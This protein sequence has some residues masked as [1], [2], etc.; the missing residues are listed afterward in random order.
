MLR[1]PFQKGVDFLSVVLRRG[2]RHGVEQK[3]GITP[4]C[5][6]LRK[7]D[8]DVAEHVS[9]KF[10]ITI[11]EI[12][13]L[14][15]PDHSGPC[16]RFQHFEQPE[17]FALIVTVRLAEAHLVDAHADQV[18]KIVN[19]VVV[20]SLP[21][22]GRPYVFCF[23]VINRINIDAPGRSYSAPASSVPPAFGRRGN[24]P[25]AIQGFVAPDG[26]Y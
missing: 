5:V 22:C 17:P 8:T 9:G 6:P 3:L 11:A 26:H 21:A 16:F 12:G 15:T 19:L 20:P 13:P 14:H 7:T 25:K 4:P 2:W 24:G 10:H 1:P 23:P 18:H